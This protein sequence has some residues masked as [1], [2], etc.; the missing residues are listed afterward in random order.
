MFASIQSGIQTRRSSRWRAAALA[1]LCVGPAAAVTPPTTPVEPRYEV[2]DAL[3]AT[4]VVVDIAV[5]PEGLGPALL[6]YDSTAADLFVPSQVPVKLV[7]YDRFSRFVSTMGFVNGRTGN[8]RDLRL[9]IDETGV[10]HAI[11]IET[12]ELGGEDDALVYFG[13]TE[14]GVPIREQIDAN[15]VFQIALAVDA[16][17]EPYVAYIKVTGAS[18]DFV[19]TLVVRRRAGGAWQQITLTPTPTTAS[20]P[21]FAP[22]PP[23]ATFFPMQLAWTENSPGSSVLRHAFVSTQ[24]ATTSTIASNAIRH[25]LS[26]PQLVVDRFG[27]LEVAYVS[28][29]DPLAP[30]VEVRRRLFNEQTWNCIDTGCALPTGALPSG[31]ALSLHGYVQGVL[32]YRDVPGTSRILRREGANWVSYALAN[33]AVAQGAALDRFGNVYTTGIDRSSH[34][35]L[36]MVRI[37]GPWESKGRIPFDS[38]TLLANPLDTASDAQGHPIIYAR[39]SCCA[40]DPRGSL[41]FVGTGNDFVE[42]ALPGAFTAAD[43][44]IAVDGDG[45]VHVAIYD[46][47]QTQLVHAAFTPGGGTEGSW[48]I[49]PVDVIGDVGLDPTMLIGTDGTPMIV[50]RRRPGSLLL[51]AR[52]ADG[53]WVGRTLAGGAL[54]ASNPVAAASSEAFRVHASWFDETAG[55]LRVSTL[56]GDPLV[57]PLASTDAVPNTPN[58]VHGNVHD[59]VVLGDG[60]VAVAYNEIIPG[61]QMQLVHRH[62]DGLGEWFASTAPE[63]FGPAQITRISLDNALL[64]PGLA[65]VAW[66]AGGRLRYGEKHPGI[67]SWQS[68]D[69][70]TLAADA[71]LQLGAAGPFRIAY[72]DGSGLFVLQRLEGLGSG[73][74]SEIYGYSSSTFSFARRYCLCVLGFGLTA[75]NVVE[76]AGLRGSAAESMD[77]QAGAIRTPSGS[78]S[79]DVLADMR[80]LF[81]TTPAGSYYL[82]LFREHA[83]EIIRLT[84]G[85]PSLLLQRT[86]TLA[87]L[88]PGMYAL[89]QSPAAGQAYRFQ[90]ELI[91]NARAVWQGWASNG[92]PALA[93]AVNNELARTNQLNQFTD[94]TFTQWFNAL[95]TGN[96]TRDLFA[97]G[98]E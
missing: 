85:N 79:G 91:A 59:I 63:P 56:L 47:D 23:Q 65:R 11:A 26:T 45:V 92:S 94:M 14:Q 54:D 58:R 38:N 28:A 74:V 60:G 68:E 90:P 82:R 95:S 57:T 50:Y 18:P 62:R 27:T 83:P 2:V 17:H 33:I 64:A 80:E 21:S 76:C 52:G 8:D 49:E 5:D 13:T 66:I 32:N 42:R 10:A 9:A 44:S 22:H 3:G 20:T 73:G 81:A 25:S 67:V 43:A 15:N 97:D 51:A 71:P 96:A 88:T 41:W 39:R 12:N 89:L 75:Q 29:I 55:V 72:N 1:C 16:T 24:T 53:I 40:P 78:P 4:D 84:L 93:S 37:G 34:D 86:R 77:G 19:R 35:D 31:F 70:G 98:F 87:D 30:T 36:F 61:P 6:Y 69:L 48:L 46:S 7:R